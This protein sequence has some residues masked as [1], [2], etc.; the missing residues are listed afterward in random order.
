ML[1]EEVGVGAW[2]QTFELLK[3]SQANMTICRVKNASKQRKAENEPGSAV[4]IQSQCGAL[5]VI[6]ESN[7]VLFGRYNEEHLDE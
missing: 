7:P 3:T 2:G 5:F 1:L 6:N 4:V